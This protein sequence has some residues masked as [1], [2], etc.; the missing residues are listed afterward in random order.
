MGKIIR[1]PWVVEK[2]EVAIKLV[3]IRPTKVKLYKLLIEERMPETTILFSS[4]YGEAINHI[5]NNAHRIF[6]IVTPDFYFDSDQKSNDFAK[7]VKGINPRNKVH[8][9][10]PEYPQD[11]KCLD[12]ISTGFTNRDEEINVLINL[13]K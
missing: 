1:P 7:E 8:L 10:S 3:I 6:C 12:S 2:N 11:I 4:F 9:Y 13:L 5:K